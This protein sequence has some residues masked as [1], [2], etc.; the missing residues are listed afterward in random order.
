MES[1]RQ[2]TCRLF[3]L[4]LI[5]LAWTAAACGQGSSAPGGLSAVPGD[6]QA[7]AS[8]TAAQT[9]AIFGLSDLMEKLRTM[10]AERGAGT[11][12]T[13][14]ERMTRLDLLEAIETAALEV[15]DVVGEISNERNELGDL[16]TALQIR[17]D[18]TVGQYTT[19]ALLT[20]SALGTAVTATQFSTLGTKVQNTGDGI[21]LG[22]GVLSTLFSIQAARKQ[23]G[24]SAPV[25][26][27][28]ICLH[29]CWG[30]NRL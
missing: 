6:G 20:G 26:K 29:P 27:V 4:T 2:A 3:T 28:R 22:S 11:A 23:S 18:K 9:A 14:E 25:G 13:L 24:P 12:P 21:G 30:A 16:R 10:R 8:A 15:D 1:L 7:V 17:R 5:S 19:A